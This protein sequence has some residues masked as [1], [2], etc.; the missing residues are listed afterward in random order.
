M[1]GMQYESDITKFIRNF[2]E[3]HPE[4]IA[5]QRI[6]RS[7]WWDKPPPERTAP[8]PPRHAPKSGGA[9]YTFRPLSER[10]E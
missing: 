3:Q 6:S 2:L 1:T 9:E 4:E 5:S 8:A 7:I 10:E